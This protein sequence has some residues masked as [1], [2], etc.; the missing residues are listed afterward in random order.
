MATIEFEDGRLS[1][2]MI[3]ERRS[4]ST[5]VKGL[6]DSLPQGS[7][8]ALL[9]EEFALHYPEAVI[10]TYM[11]SD[12]MLNGVVIGRLV[13]FRKVYRGSNLVTYSGSGL[14]LTLEEP[15][16]GILEYVGTLSESETVLEG[17]WRIFEK[18]FFGLRERII[19]T[20]KFRLSR[21][22]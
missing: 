1:G 4:W 17:H 8:T 7:K 15:Q 3:D 20:G 22:G 10:T 5:P 13:K 14:D 9:W 21:V 18:S 19:A 12:S 2:T 11:P 16:E 6:H